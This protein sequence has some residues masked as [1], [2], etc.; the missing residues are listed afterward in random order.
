M[1]IGGRRAWFRACITPRAVGAWG[2]ATTAGWCS[3][4]PWAWAAVCDG[5]PRQGC[6]GALAAVADGWWAGGGRS[7]LAAGRSRGSPCGGRLGGGWVGDPPFRGAD[8]VTCG[9]AHPVR[10]RVGQG[11]PPDALQLERSVAGPLSTHLVPAMGPVHDA[12]PPADLLEERPPDLRGRENVGEGCSAPTGRN[13]VVGLSLR[14][15]SACACGPQ[16]ILGVWGLCAPA[17]PRFGP[18]SRGP[19]QPVTRPWGSDAPR[20]SPRPRRGSG[21]TTPRWP[22]CSTGQRPRRPVASC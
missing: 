1:K 21:R 20:L 8:W 12:L 9:T 7:G 19:N 22:L 3:P 10:L 4:G 5:T 16:A 11:S 2:F 13:A 17:R 14:D 15:A 6:C 18:I